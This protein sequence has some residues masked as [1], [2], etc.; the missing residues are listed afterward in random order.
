MF[1]TNRYRKKA[2]KLI[3]LANI[4]AV[5][6]NRIYDKFPIL[7]DLVHDDRLLV[8]LM[9]VAGVVQGNTQI[10]ENVSKRQLVKFLGAV[11]DELRKWDFLGYK[12]FGDESAYTA[13]I[14]LVNF[15]KEKEGNEYFAVIGYWLISNLKGSQ[16]G[17]EEIAVGIAI[18][19]LLES[20]LSGWGDV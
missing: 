8:F 4:A 5:S 15:V 2:K 9:T 16:P 10:D 1:G 14:N 3:S 17:H 18:S 20:S 6:S 19:M 12:P 13:Y 7:E 11:A